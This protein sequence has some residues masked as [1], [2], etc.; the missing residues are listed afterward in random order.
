MKIVARLYDVED[1]MNMGAPNARSVIID[2]GD[3]IPQMLKDWDR[4]RKAY[5][6]RHKDRGYGTV[7]P[8]DL[9]FSLLIEEDKL[10]WTPP[11]DTP[12]TSATVEIIGK[13]HDNP[14]LLEVGE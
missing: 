13:I 2:L 12:C 10:G 4:Q 14:E 1:A 6:E 7:Y 9:S 5:E 8:V 11:K 3:N